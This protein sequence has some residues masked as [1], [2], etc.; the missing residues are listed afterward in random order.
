MLKLLEDPDTA[1]VDEE[2][3]DPRI[4]TLT[5]IARAKRYM[6]ELQ[7]GHQITTDDLVDN[8][9]MSDDNISLIE[10]ITHTQSSNPNWHLLRQGMVTASRFHRV[11]TRTDTLMRDPSADP[12]K[13]LDDI[14]QDPK[15]LSGVESLEYGKNCEPK[16]RELYVKYQKREHSRLKVQLQGLQLCPEHPFVGCSVD[17][18]VSC[19]CHPNRIIEIKCPSALK[20]SSPK[21]AAM[22]RGCYLDAEN[23]VKLKRNTDFFYQ[24]Q[25]QLGLYHLSS[26]DLVIYT[27]KGIFIVKVDFDRDFFNLMM[28]KICFFYRKYCAA[29]L[30]KKTAREMGLKA[31]PH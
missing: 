25:G 5:V 13:L 23:T 1:I 17:G 18:L 20:S 27:E 30:L 11:C 6:A 24:I 26:C 14:F 29:F 10:N 19:S 22:N 4:T 16:A 31:L 12:S 15:M 7:P 3:I 8:L 2:Q 9:K 28:A 21:E